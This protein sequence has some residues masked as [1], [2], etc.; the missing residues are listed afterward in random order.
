M[1]DVFWSQRL[2]NGQATMIKCKLCGKFCK[3]I[4]VE[5]IDLMASINIEPLEPI[6]VCEKCA[7]ELKP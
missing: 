5:P 1:Q 4:A 2:F 6:L 7:K 3:P